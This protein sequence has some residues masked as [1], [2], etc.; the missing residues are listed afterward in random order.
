MRKG[1]GFSGFSLFLF[2]DSLLHPSWCR[3]LFQKKA[4]PCP[5]G[6]ACSSWEPLKSLR[7]PGFSP[8]N[9]F[10]AK[11]GN[12]FQLGFRMAPTVRGQ[13]WLSLAPLGLKQ[14]SGHRKPYP[15]PSPGPA[16]KRHSCAWLGLI[17]YVVLQT[18]PTMEGNSTH[19]Q[20]ALP[21]STQSN[22]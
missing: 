2:R 10:R 4:E 21:A 13:G 3:L 22:L 1:S 15:A 11:V 17:P 9:S 12:L 8:V 16:E 6:A 18:A 5:L 7:T 20:K 14:S 19:F